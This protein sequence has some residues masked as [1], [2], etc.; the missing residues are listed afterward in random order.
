MAPRKFDQRFQIK[1]MMKEGLSQK[2][3]KAKLDRIHGVNA[4]SKSSIQRW[5]SQ[6]WS[7]CIQKD[8]LPKSGAPTK[9]TAAKIQAV[10][11]SMTNNRRSTIRQLAEDVQ[12]SFGCTQ[13]ILKENLKLIKCPAKWVPHLLITDELTCHV[14]HSS[15]FT[16]EATPLTQWSPRMSPGSTAGTWSPTTKPRSGCL[17]MMT[18]L[19]RSALN[20]LSAKWCSLCFWISKVWCTGNLFQMVMESERNFTLKFWIISWL[21]SI[22]DALIWLPDK[23]WDSGHSSRMVRQHTEHEMSLASSD[24]IMSRFSPTQDTALISTLWITGFSTGSKPRSGGSGITI[25]TN[26]NKPLMLPS[27]LSNPMRS[28][29]PWTDFQKGCASALMQKEDILRGDELFLCL[30]LFQKISCWC[31]YFQTDTHHNG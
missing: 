9:W 6:F 21:V 3:M 29:T 16:R 1:F 25:W 28:L 14:S 19:K 30:T 13:W 12:L 17:L 27:Q 18:S 4:L 2:D 7:R 24:N 15:S 8:N 20:A 10:H 5:H 11:T 23:A 22:G 26:C 31:F